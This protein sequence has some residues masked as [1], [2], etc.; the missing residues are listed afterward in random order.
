MTQSSTSLVGSQ[1]APEE[2]GGIFCQ[3][4]EQEF[5]MSVSI[6][7]GLGARSSVRVGDSFSG[8]S[9]RSLVRFNCKIF[10]HF[11]VQPEESLP[12][13]LNDL[14]AN[15]RSASRLGS[16]RSENAL[17]LKAFKV[18]SSPKASLGTDA[19]NCLSKFIK[20]FLRDRTVFLVGTSKHGSRMR[21]MWKTKTSPPFM[22]LNTI[23]K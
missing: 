20:L 1:R 13:L 12:R 17:I 4:S 14:A 2:G 8:R 22:K 7:R 10:L 21:D 18:L 5:P 3:V 23:T 6:R 11:I 16:T 15:D 9:N 19:H